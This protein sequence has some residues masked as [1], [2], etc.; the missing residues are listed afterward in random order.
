MSAGCNSGNLGDSQRRVS[1]FGSY[2]VKY[3]RGQGS[4]L[5]SNYEVPLVP[6]GEH[7][8]GLIVS[9]RLTLQ[10][11]SP[12]P[13]EAR[14]A[15]AALACNSGK[16]SGFHSLHRHPHLSCL[17]KLVTSRSSFQI[18]LVSKSAVSM[19]RLSSS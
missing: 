13:P 5:I 4:R 3:P 7:L 1:G 12:A 18:L 9:S 11:A 14:P 2:L 6:P 15:P 17:D 8:R 10:P 19:E 16:F